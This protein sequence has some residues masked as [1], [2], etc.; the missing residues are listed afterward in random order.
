MSTRDERQREMRNERLRRYRRHHKGGQKEIRGFFEDPSDVAEFL[1]EAGVFVPDA[2][3]E[4]L[5]KCMKV[6]I[7]LWREGAIRVTRCHE[8]S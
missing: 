5:G 1:H 8:S 7:D 4:T 3:P 2:H 6:L